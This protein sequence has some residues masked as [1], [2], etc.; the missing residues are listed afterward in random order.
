L[1]L[2]DANE[3][4]DAAGRIDAARDV[5]VIVRWRWPA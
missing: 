1:K 4:L 3:A 5:D 2:H